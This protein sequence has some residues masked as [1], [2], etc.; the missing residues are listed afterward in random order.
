MIA[1]TIEI[2]FADHEHFSDTGILN[3]NQSILKIPTSTLL[4]TG[5]LV[6]TQR[7]ISGTTILA[8]LEFQRLPN[9]HLASN[10]SMERE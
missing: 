2:Q 1:Q 5:I 4:D 10:E 6:P 8:Y 9:R 3:S 7:C